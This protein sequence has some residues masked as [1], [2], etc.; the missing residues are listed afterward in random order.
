MNCGQSGEILA[1]SDRE[2][3]AWYWK[4][5]DEFRDHPDRNRLPLL[6]R[7]ARRRGLLDGWRDVSALA[8]VDPRAA[9]LVDPP[10][11]VDFMVAL[12][13]DTRPGRVLDPWAGLGVTLR[14]LDDAGLVQEGTGLELNLEVHELAQELNES[15][16]LSWICANAGEFLPRLDEEFDLVVGSP[17]MGLPPINLET[18]DPEIHLRASATYTMLIQAALKLS[19]NGQIAVILP[20]GFLQPAAQAVRD[21]LATVSVFISAAFALPARAFRTKLP[22]SLVVFDREPHEDLFVAE[23]DPSVDVSALL[24]NYRARREAKLPQL[25]R[26]VQA[27][28][29]T[30]WKHVTRDADIRDMARRAGL[31]PV[32]INQ[33]CTAIRRPAKNGDP[34][35]PAVH[36]VYLPSI[37][38]SP[39]VT[40]LDELVIKPQNYV[41]LVVDLEIADPAYVAGFLNSPLGRLVREQLTGGAT[42]P[43]LSV[44]R[45]RSGTMFLPPLLE[46]Q[47]RVSAVSRSLRELQIEIQGLEKQAWEHPLAAAQT[48]Q[49]LRRLLEGDGFERWMDSLPFPLA[50]ILWRYNVSD[51]TEDRCR[52]LINFFEATTLFLVDLHWSALHADVDLDSENAP[53]REPVATTYTRGSIGIWAHLLTRLAKRTRSLLSDDRALALDLFRVADP[54]RLDAISAKVV[55]RSLK[56]EAAQ[57]RIDWIA[58]TA[59]TTA[60]EWLQRLSLAE[61]TLARIREGLAD[62]FD[63]WH[64]VRTGHGRR[65][66]GVVTTSLEFVTGSRALF[67]QGEADLRELPDDGGLYMLEQDSSSPLQLAPLISLRG[68]PETVEDACY[69]YDRIEGG[70]VRWISYHYAPRSEVV[71][72]DDRVVAMIQELDSLG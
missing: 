68:S 32:P 12:C 31:L 62:A 67:R 6:L 35:A 69:F 41:Q 42:I 70:S 29:F 63:G 14:A 20:Q 1:A 40:S 64:L 23:L 61:E 56:D 46:Q 38:T 39:A 72:V 57:Y 54:A 15:S 16:R 25:G 19:P 59:P 36:C 22:T 10:V 13:R 66:N 2:Q 51:D 4:L 55:S 18:A 30:S 71:A 5:A 11:V 53:D 26:L 17:P 3:L 8:R 47:R 58:H 48:E 37:G 52:H 65:R 33:V 49:R 21:S 24:E 43:H 27:D 9:E 45:I 28:T 7:E 34:F 44:D 50:S 60:A